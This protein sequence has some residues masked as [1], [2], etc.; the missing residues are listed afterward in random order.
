MSQSKYLCL[1]V[2]FFYP[3]L[4]ECLN[5]KLY[6]QER[7][8]RCLCVD[9]LAFNKAHVHC[10]LRGWSMDRV[11]ESWAKQSRSS[12]L[13]ASPAP[14][15]P[16]Y[17]LRGVGTLQGMFL[18]LPLSVSLSLFHSFHFLFLDPT[19]SFLPASLTLSVIAHYLTLSL[20]KFS[21]VELPC[22]WCFH[23][24]NFVHKRSTIYFTHKL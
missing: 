19:L 1:F 10:W 7:A 12:V 2:L 20:L 21:T 16:D 9:E 5:N 18:S 17:S 14:S 4:G 23:R 22:W 13:L 8:W 15:A 3:N 6:P 24:R 11:W